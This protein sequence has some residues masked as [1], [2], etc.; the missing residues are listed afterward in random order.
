[1]ATLPEIVNWL[2]GDDSLHLGRLIILV[3]VFAG[4]RGDQTIDGITKLAKLDFLLRYPAYL[5][6]AL[7][8]RNAPEA[9]ALVQE[10]ER[11]SVEARMVRYK[12]GPW[13]HRY[14]RFLNILVGKGFVEVKDG[15]PVVI[16]LTPK[17]REAAESLL[18]QPEYKSVQHRASL[19]KQ[20]M[21]LG[22]KAL[23]DFIY[24]IFPEVTSL[25]LG[26]TIDQ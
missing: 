6:R 9:A 11:N 8:A 5:E 24:K 25:R 15:R 10:Y 3:D 2:E 18:V 21:N 7:V 13:D 26:E 22:A 14:R 17:G 12:F 23:M 19:L 1:M 4:R 20:H 16:R